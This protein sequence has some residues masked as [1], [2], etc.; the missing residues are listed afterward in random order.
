VKAYDDRPRPYSLLRIVLAALT[1]A[2]ITSGC[3]G[4][5]TD[6][7]VTSLKL[8]PS[9][10]SADHLAVSPG[11]KVQFLGFDNL[12]TLPAGCFTVAV[13]QAP[14]SDLKWV[15]SDP[16]NV[17][18]GNT[19]NVDYGLATCNNSTSSPVTITATGPNSTNATI[20]GTATLT[21]K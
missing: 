8:Q 16:V 12:T 15:S 20:S 13:L 1:V 3:G 14:R 4:R 9:T 2:T 10:A 21:C 17:S 7:T 19:Q 11:N 6:C 5:T 18:V